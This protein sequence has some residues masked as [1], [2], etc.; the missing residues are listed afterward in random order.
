M[1]VSMLQVK[2]HLMGLVGLLDKV[3][4]TGQSHLPKIKLE[5]E[6]LEEEVTAFGG[7]VAQGG[8]Q[9]LHLARNAGR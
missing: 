9:E 1:L 4:I 8:G 7:H 6:L 2:N 3:H 5:I